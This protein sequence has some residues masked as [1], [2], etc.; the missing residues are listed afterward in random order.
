MHS[1]PTLKIFVLIVFV[2][3]IFYYY[4]SVLDLVPRLVF[5]FFC[6][7]FSE[8]G[9]FLKWLD[10]RVLNGNIDVYKLCLCFSKKNQS[11]VSLTHPKLAYG[12]IFEFSRLEKKIN[13][14]FGITL[15]IWYNAIMDFLRLLM[16]KEAKLYLI[17]KYISYDHD[18]S[19][20]SL[21]SHQQH[22]GQKCIK[23]RYQ[24]LKFLLK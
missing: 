8:L 11:I 4:C 12:Q 21:F 2:Q 1:Q 5:V 22:R 15:V 10:E 13:L 24:P 16:R 14:Y 23:K 18:R 9:A 19:K 6:F 3:F 20:S 17:V 7:V